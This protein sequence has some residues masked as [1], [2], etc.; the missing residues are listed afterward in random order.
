[1][2]VRSCVYACVRLNVCA[3]VRMCARACVF[4][5]ARVCACVLRVRVCESAEIGRDG[6][7]SGEVARR[8]HEGEVGEARAGDAD[9]DVDEDVARKHTMW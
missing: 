5:R 6:G 8:L 3:C 4:A 2:H 9:E 7:R 1:M